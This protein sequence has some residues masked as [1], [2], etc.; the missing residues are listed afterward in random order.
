MNKEYTANFNPLEDG[1]LEVTFSDFP[2][3][4][5]VADDLNEAIRLAQNALDKATGEI[6]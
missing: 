2:E 4:R 5:L 3:I 6:S 1:T